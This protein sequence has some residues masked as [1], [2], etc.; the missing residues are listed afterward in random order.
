MPELPEVQT[1]ISDL[2]PLL[3]GRTIAD[4]R[5]AWPKAVQAPDVEGFIT[6]LLGQRIAG[7]ERRGKYI[8]FALAGGRHLVL[9]LKMTGAL[10]WRRAADPPDRFTQTVFAL[11]DGHELRFTDVRKFGRLWLVDD[12]REA[13]PA[14]GPEP[15]DGAFTAARLAQALRGR[16]APIKAC[17]CDQGVVAGVGNIYADEALFLAGVHPL[18]QAGDLRRVEVA[19]LRDAVVA[20]LEQGIRNRGTSFD[21]YRDGH[22]NKGSNQLAVNVYQRKG[23]PCTR[24]G[25]PVQRTLVGQR[26]AHFCPRCQPRRT[27]KTKGGAP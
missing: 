9:H 14:L 10:L 24:C 23:Q 12:L 17:L 16:R 27:G 25:T 4:V 20:V 6:G 22:G 2:L 1:I 5:L 3:R 13:L 7:V 21:T 18:R 8:V 11:D 15:L 26:S 19:R